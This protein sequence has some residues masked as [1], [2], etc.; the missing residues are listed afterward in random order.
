MR[1]IRDKL[2]LNNYT[3][4]TLLTSITNNTVVIGL[5]AILVIICS[6]IIV[7]ATLSSAITAG[8][9]ACLFSQVIVNLASKCLPSNIKVMV[10]TNVMRN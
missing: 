3:K 2:M 5:V 10:I 8:N 4:N 6:I 9:D 1:W 7:I